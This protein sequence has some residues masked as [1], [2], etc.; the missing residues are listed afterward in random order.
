MLL[1]FSTENFLS[2]KDKITLSMLATNDK[3]LD[4]NLIRTDDNNYL[5]TIAIY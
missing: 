5:K 2:I 4:H 1:Q 3:S